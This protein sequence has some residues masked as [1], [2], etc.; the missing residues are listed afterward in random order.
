MILWTLRHTKP[1]NPTGV[2]YGRLNFDVS[3]SFEEE[4]APAI[5]AI[6][7]NAHPTRLF[8]SPL[9][10]C[11]RFA[12]KVSE[13]IQLPVETVDALQ[14]VHFGSWEN[15]KLTD[16][17]KS[18]MSAWKNDLRGYRFPGGESFHDVEIRVQN[19]L[20]TLLGEKEVL[21]VTHAG[22]IGAIEH[23]VCGLSDEYF[24]EGEFPYAM[25]TRFE[26]EAATDGSLRGTFQK[27]YGG[28]P[29]MSLSELIK[30]L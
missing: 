7:E 15:V 20:K 21:C 22:V 1:F 24:V 25:L 27:V 14:E 3:P 11:Q 4:A 5:S 18:E 30:M 28:I 9:L 6:L 16:V 10:R 17:P 29:Q 26:I 23:S 12:K 13:A 19:F 8:A 2:C